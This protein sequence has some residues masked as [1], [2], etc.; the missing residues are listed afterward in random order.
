MS[1]RPFEDYLQGR[2]L[3]GE[4]FT[5]EEREAWFRSEQEAYYKVSRGAEKRSAPRAYG[6]HAMNRRLGFS[7]LPSGRFPKV[8]SVGGAFG[9]ELLPIID[10]VDSVTI[11]EPGEGFASQTINGV[12]V[13]YVPPQASGLLTLPDGLFSL[14]TCFGTLHHISDVSTVVREIARCAAPGAYILIREPIISMGDWTRPRPMLTERERGIP[15]RLFDEI[16]ESAGLEVVRR[17]LCMFAAFNP[18]NAR[19]GGVYARRMLVLLDELLCLVTAWHCRYH[20]VTKLQ[21][22]TP[23][24]VFYVLRKP[25]W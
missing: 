10:R 25:G 23:T 3:Y 4:D 22:L 2:A 13:T 12:P 1:Q 8:L 18:I 5:P 16:I 15:L 7:H 21:K 11:V 6:Y 20:R 17:R 9:D 14:V 19:W 24:S